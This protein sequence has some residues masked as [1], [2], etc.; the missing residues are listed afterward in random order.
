MPTSERIQR[1]TKGK[2]ERY[3]DD[4]DDGSGVGED[5]DLLPITSG[6]GKGKQGKCYRKV[7]SI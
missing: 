4:D 7:I 2:T 3:G 1:S 6:T 5:S